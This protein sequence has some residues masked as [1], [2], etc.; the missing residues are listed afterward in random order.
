[1]FK[2]SADVTPTPKQEGSSQQIGVDTGYSPPLPYSQSLPSRSIGGDGDR[3]IP[4]RPRFSLNTSRS[5]S[6]LPCHFNTLRPIS[7]PSPNGSTGRRYVGKDI[8]SSEIAAPSRPSL[9]GPGKQSGD[10]GGHGFRCG[11]VPNLDAYIDLI[12]Q[13]PKQSLRVS[14]PPLR[15]PPC[16]RCL[17]LM[18]GRDR[19]TYH[20]LPIDILLGKWS[21]H[22]SVTSIRLHQSG[23]RI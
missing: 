4:Q 3:T 19:G 6:S 9:G 17:T 16:P 23:P 7:M 1:M 22:R 8:T 12:P 21:R 5:S 2:H 15:D 13:G 14:P 18:F 20:A 10:E 11:F